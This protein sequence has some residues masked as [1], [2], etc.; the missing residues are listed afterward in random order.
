SPS[1][2][3][4][5]LLLYLLLYSGGNSDL[6]ARQ[7]GKTELHA[8]QGFVKRVVA[9]PLGNVGAGF[10][11]ESEV[12]VE[13]MRHDSLVLP[14]VVADAEMPFGD[15]LNIDR[16]AIFERE[17]QSREQGLEVVF[18]IPDDNGILAAA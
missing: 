15:D 8:S 14:V 11:D 3:M 2:S 4:A 10:G 1:A 7:P 13:F 18:R 9:N 17:V 5:G 16:P 6:I 12:R